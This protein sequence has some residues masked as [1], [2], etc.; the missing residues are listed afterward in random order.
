MRGVDGNST[1]PLWPKLAGQHAF[2]LAK[3]LREFRAGKRA[4]PSMRPNEPTAQ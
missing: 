1:N 2:Y 4:D 3:Q